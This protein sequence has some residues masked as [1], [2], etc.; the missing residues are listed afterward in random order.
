MIAEFFSDSSHG[1]TFVN[2]IHKKGLPNI[3]GRVK[4]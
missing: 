1:I 3:A 4:E 2:A